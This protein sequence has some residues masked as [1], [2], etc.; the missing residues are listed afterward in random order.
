M[1]GAILIIAPFPD[2]CVFKKDTV[3]GEHSNDQ[4]LDAVAKALFDEVCADEGR[5]G[6]D[7]EVD[8]ADALV[9]AVMIFGREGR[10]FTEHAM[11][12]A[13]VAYG[14]MEELAGKRF[15]TA[16]NPR[17]FMG[18]HA[19]PI[20][21]GF[22][23]KSHLVIGIPAGMSDLSPEV[24]GAPRDAKTVGQSRR[25]AAPDVFNRFAQFRRDSFISV[26]PENP[27]PGG[28]RIGEFVLVLVAPKWPVEDLVRVTAR[29]L[30]RAVCRVGIDNDDLVRPRNRFADRSDV[31][32]FVIDDDS[33]G[34]SQFFFGF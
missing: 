27:I 10:I 20:T 8:P 5:D 18:R 31:G 34:D 16:A 1:M 12:L 17:R 19:V 3:S 6:Q 13:Q 4:S 30:D 21:R 14:V 24:M 7:E 15:D 23:I 32:F 33:G 28:L 22:S 9:F 29:D 11:M 25:V 2:F 26:D